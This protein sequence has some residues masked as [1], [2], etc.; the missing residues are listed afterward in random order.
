MLAVE[1]LP[2]PASRCDSCEEPSELIVSTARGAALWLCGRCAD[3]LV[4][5]LSGLVA[6]RAKCLASRS[7]SEQEDDGA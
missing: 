1:I 7:R 5:V 4:L 2:R 6:D 3:R